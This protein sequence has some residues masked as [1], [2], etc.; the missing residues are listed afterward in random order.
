MLKNFINQ[1]K[2]II[3]YIS[4]NNIIFSKLSFLLA[5]VLILIVYLIKLLIHLKNKTY[6]YIK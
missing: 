3:N 6:P 1:I 5:Q 4:Q 2:L